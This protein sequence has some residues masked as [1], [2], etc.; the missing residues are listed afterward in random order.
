MK[1]FVIASVAAGAMG[2]ASAHAGIFQD[3][4]RGLQIVST[5]SGSPVLPQVDGSRVNGQRVG[6]VRIVPETLGQGY[7]VEFNRNFGLDTTGRP[8]TFDLGPVDLEL[9]G[10]TAMT[11]GFTRR[12]FLIGTM[13][14]SANS[15][16]YL[17]RAKTGAQNAEL[18]GTIDANGTIEINQFGFYDASV[19]VTNANSRLTVDGVL[20]DD[21]SETDLGIGPIN[22][23]GNIFVDLLAAG[24]AH[25]G[26]DTTVLETLFPRSPIDQITNAID[27]A[28]PLDAAE[29]AGLLDG[30]VAQPRFAEALG[31]E[32]PSTLDAAIGSV[33]TGAAGALP[34]P[35]TLALL[36]VGAAALLRRR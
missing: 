31:I 36:A 15:L 6:R 5:P 1:R 27:L 10:A 26:V 24:L 18:S 11:A 35:G 23:Q 12:G 21:F 2:A 17:L 8:E 3:V 29:A 9:N 30:G 33:P 4:F 16:D 28:R 32:L 19:L 7:S 25:A 14:F 22:V 13:N 34:E 20:A